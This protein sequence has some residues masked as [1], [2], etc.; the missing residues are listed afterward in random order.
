MN[1]GT[2]HTFRS[3]SKHWNHILTVFMILLIIG[4]NS[5]FYRAVSDGPEQSNLAKKLPYESI[6]CTTLWGTLR[7][8]CFNKCQSSSTARKMSCMTSSEG[9]T[10]CIPPNS[11]F[12]WELHVIPCMMLIWMVLE[13]K[14]PWATWEG[15]NWFCTENWGVKRFWLGSF[16]YWKK[17]FR[18]VWH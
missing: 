14:Y 4:Q 16:M 15:F 13:Y 1:I 7:N 10:D 8:K 11:W 5:N 17:S 9:S 18:S 3:L 12:M 2:V 6:K